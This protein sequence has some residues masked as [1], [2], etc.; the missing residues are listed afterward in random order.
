MYIQWKQFLYLLALNNPRWVDMLLESIIRDY[1]NFL[2][3]SMGQGW[4]STSC[5]NLIF[6]LVLYPKLLNISKKMQSNI[7]ILIF[8][9]YNVISKLLKYWYH[10]VWHVW[11]SIYIFLLKIIK[12]LVQ[13]RFKPHDLILFYFNF[14]RIII[15]F[16]CFSINRIYFHCV[17]KKKKIKKVLLPVMLNITL[18][19]FYIYLFFLP[20]SWYP[21]K[22][23]R[24]FL[25]SFHMCVC[26]G[27]YLARVNLC[28]F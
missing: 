7:K 26:G 27:W 2:F 18:T 12:C 17:F 19:M 11:T 28:K 21:C 4:E 5:I 24:K 13:W 10:F 16:L 9:K 23:T 6:C 20:S 1:L 15:F 8:C 22:Y 25:S 14:K 3:L